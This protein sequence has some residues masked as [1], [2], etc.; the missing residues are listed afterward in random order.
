MWWVQAKFITSFPFQNLDT[1]QCRTTASSF[2]ALQ[3]LLK[4]SFQRGSAIN[5]L[6]FN[7]DRK[8]ELCYLPLEYVYV[9]CT[10]DC[11][12]MYENQELKRW[13]NKIMR[14]S[15][16]VLA[17]PGLTFALS[18][19]SIKYHLVH[20]H[21]PPSVS[22]ANESSLLCN[23]RPCVLHIFTLVL[24]IQL[25]ISSWVSLCCSALSGLKA[26]HRQWISF[27]PSATRWWH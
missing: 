27:H 15:C 1:E 11:I 26:A 5:T 12:K 21:N 10:V 8:E 23:S 24:K 17:W 3:W 7:L 16:T 22:S 6:L 20:T 2:I 4:H 9:L 18:F 14:I 19:E 13:G 25:L